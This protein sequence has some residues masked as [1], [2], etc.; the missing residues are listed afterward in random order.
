MIEHADNVVDLNAILH[1]GS[2]Y[3]HPRD[4]LTDQTISTVEKRAI[5]ASWASDAAAVVS[6]PALREVP[7][8]HRTVTIDDVLEALSA[9]D[10]GPKEPP[11]GKPARTK[12]VARAGLAA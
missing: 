2:V 12:S 10:Q 3:D 5:L 11:G 6:N 4:V 1:P 9:L 7:G 8:S